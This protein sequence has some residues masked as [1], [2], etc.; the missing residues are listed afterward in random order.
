MKKSRVYTRTGDAGTTSLVGGKRVAKTHAR[1]EAYGTI[2]ELNAYIGLL[3]T[4]VVDEGCRKF[5]QQVQHTLFVAGAQLATET[6]QAD[7]MHVTAQMVEAME[8]E[9]DIIDSLLPRQQAFILPG[10]SRGAALCHVCRTV[11]R[12][13]ERRALALVEQTKIEQE[14]LSYLNRLSDYFFVLGRKMNLDDKKDEI[15]WE[16]TWR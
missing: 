11:C 12:R 13:A 15:F 4:Y 9:I 2:D 1:L 8:L 16:N 5:L 7:G 10:G 6:V 3:V 14:L